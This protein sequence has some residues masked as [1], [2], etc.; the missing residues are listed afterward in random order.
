[1]NMVCEDQSL[2]DQPTD[3]IVAD[4]SP[5]IVVFSF[6]IPVEPGSDMKMQVY[7]QDKLGRKELIDDNALVKGLQSVQ[8]FLNPCPDVKKVI[9]DFYFLRQVYSKAAREDILNII[10]QL[11]IPLLPKY[12]IGCTVD[13]KEGSPKAEVCVARGTIMGMIFALA[14]EMG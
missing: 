11:L 8:E 7:E 4:G 10:K 3:Q 14:P 1:M 13:L 5:N 9:F 12:S 6:P 2:N